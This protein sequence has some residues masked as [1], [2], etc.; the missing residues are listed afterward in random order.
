[1]TNIISDWLT[2]RFSIACPHSI[3]E[4]VLADLLSRDRRSPCVLRKLPQALEMA[5]A[6]STS[7]VMKNMPDKMIVVEHKHRWNAARKTMRCHEFLAT[8]TET[9]FYWRQIP[10]S[11]LTSRAIPPFASLERADTIFF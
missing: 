11:E 1:M 4:G 5:G 9:S 6:L 10:I 8:L 2:R 3:P 7:S